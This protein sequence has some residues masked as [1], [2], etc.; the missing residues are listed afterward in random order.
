MI[1]VKDIVFEDYWYNEFCDETE[2]YFEAPKSYLHGEYPEADG[3][4]FVLR[5][6]GKEWNTDNATVEISPFN[7]YKDIRSDYDWCP[8]PCSKE[9]K[10]TLYDIYENHLRGNTYDYQQGREGT[11][12]K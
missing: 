2:I 1:E 12:K 11:Q 10:Q 5:Y 3:C 8:Y 6:S 7:D 9:F 4:T